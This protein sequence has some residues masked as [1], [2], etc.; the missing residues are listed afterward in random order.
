MR[1]EGLGMRLGR[2][3][4]KVRRPGNETQEAWE[5]GRGG[6]GTRLCQ[7]SACV[8][9]T[10]NVLFPHHSKINGLFGKCLNVLRRKIS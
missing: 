7:E 6:L 5:Q 8:T 1:S 10:N 4:N 3:G 2:P 9:L